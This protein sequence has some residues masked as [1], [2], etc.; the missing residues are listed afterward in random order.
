MRVLLYVLFIMI[1]GPVALGS[2]PS[3]NNL[4]VTVVDSQDALVPNAR[5]LLSQADQ[6][7][8]LV[9]QTTSAEGKTTFTALR[10]GEYRVR[11]LA[12]G[13]AEEEARVGAPGEHT[14]KLHVAAASENVTVSATRTPVPTEESGAAVASL[15]ADELKNMQPVDEAEALRFLPGAIIGIAGRQGGLS[16]LFVRGGDSRYN[17]VIVDDVTVDEPGGT[18]D[19]GVVPMVEIDRLE[20]VRGAASDLY[21]SDAMTSV[22][23][24]WSREG[25]TRV[26]E[27]RFGADGGSFQAAHGYAS[28]AGA[29]GRFDYNVFGD[30]FNTSGQGINDDYSNSSQGGNVGIKLSRQISF[31][32]RA[33]HSN[34]RTGIQ[35]AWN[36]N[37]LP[38]L[39]PDRDQRARQNN[40]LSSGEIT[41]STSRSIHRFTGFEYRHVRLNEDDVVDPGIVSPLYGNVDFPFRLLNDFNRAG[42]EYQGEYWERSWAR[43]TFGYRFEDENG[44][45]NIPVVHAVRLNHDVYGQQLLTWGRAS[46]QAGLRFVQNGTFG[47]KVVPRIAGSVL[48][49][50]GGQTFSGTRL[51]GSYA[52]GIKEPRLE[53]AFANGPFAIPNPNLKPEENRSFDA[54]IEQKLGGGKYVLSATYYH[55]IF[56]NQVEFASSPVTFVGQ[57]VNVNKT[58]AHGAEFEFH[59][60]LTTRM[61]LDSAYTYTSTQVLAAHLCTPQNFCDPLLGTGAELVRRPRHSGNALLNYAS[62][63]WGGQIGATALGRR[64]DSDFLGLIPHIDH[65]AGYVRVDLG[66]WYAI[67]SHVSVYASVGNAFNRRYEEA[68][69]YPALRANFRAGLRFR[70]GGE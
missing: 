15:N 60:R 70:V 61:S 51:R 8:S 41:A 14:L 1:C 38:L 39:A 40:F 66:S 53:E 55:N 22:V 26:P 56:R 9:M 54:G 32:L 4:T 13:F 58:L 49:L 21:G 19:F 33:R 63:R 65:T 18:F 37:G 12:P 45:V 7:A 52:T 29:R 35:S 25:S 10:A 28:V 64:V 50:R 36:F 46:L 23:Q 44:F 34:N 16:S 17:K 24:T 3:A 27:L 62:R 69:G 59:A 11:V 48:M 67:N 5:V 42:F 43:T 30:Q 31:R 47:N 6:P 57:Y 68:S 20:M 2:G